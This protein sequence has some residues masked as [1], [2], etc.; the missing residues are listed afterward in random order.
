[1]AE[2]LPQLKAR[3]ELLAAE[4]AQKLSDRGDRERV[5]L[6]ETLARQRDRVREA[7][8]R[9]TTELP[10]LT[11]DFAEAERR[12]VEAD[13]R[14]WERRIDQFDRDLETEP[15]RVADFYAVAA[16]RTEPVGLVYL[17]PNTN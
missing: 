9:H 10:Q 1:M 12:Q 15:Q 5:D 14:S 8:A 2:L 11:L 4:A 6:A 7:L 3:A 13:M 17:W 16:T